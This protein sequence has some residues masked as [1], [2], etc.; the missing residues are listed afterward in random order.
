MS[1]RLKFALLLALVGAGVLGNIGAALWCFAVLER[2]LAG[3]FVSVA[4]VMRQL[5]HI[6]RG[7]EEQAALVR[8]GGRLADAKTLEP[9]QDFAEISRTIEQSLKHLHQSEWFIERTGRSTSRNLNARVEDFV[10]SGAQRDAADPGW[11]GRFTEQAHQLH[12]LIEMIEGR[13]LADA[14]LAT[15]WDDRVRQRLLL[16]L[17]L[18][19]FGA[20]LA[21]IL[22]MAFVNRWVLQP[23]SELRTAAE[24]IGAGDFTHRVRVARGPEDEI[25]ELSREVNHMASM[26]QTMQDERVD[27]ERL[28]AVG[29]LVRR[30]AHNLRNPL[31]GIRGLA[32]L[33]RDEL[34]P[35]TDLR[36]MQQR[37]ISSVDRFEQWLKDLLNATS[38]ASIERAPEEV[39]PWLSGLIDSHRPMAQAKRVNLHVD[40]AK[41]P[42]RAEIDKRHLEH[43]VAAILSNAIE[44]TPAGG[45]VT[46]RA[47]GGEDGKWELSISDQGPG[48]APEIRDRIFR[49]YFTTKR[50][51]T[52]IGLAVAQ[53]VVQ[54]H[55][56]RI[57]IGAPPANGVLTPG[58]GPGARFSI[59]LP[60]HVAADGGKT[61]AGAGGSE[62]AGG[63]NS[64]H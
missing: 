59:L 38:P 1:L 46:I 64:R 48:V 30:L 13:I 33:T 42:P 15:E 24:R 19:S 11:E 43:A 10:A 58:L 3:P 23:V 29:E 54:G 36:E 12:E 7:V 60:L 35:E 21:G 22:A 52:G 37:I 26:V 25:T 32:E 5:G 57:E 53:Q 56:G 55:G 62:A 45:H 16:V 39:G 17:F 61:E 6:K 2:E 8:G 27:R 40:L 44:A 20:V 41:A 63:Q 51:G 49:P 47:T 18:S 14:A 9:Q 50:D 4:S 34:P 31:A 28:A